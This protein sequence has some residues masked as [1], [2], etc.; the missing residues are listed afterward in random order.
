MRPQ[1]VKILTLM[2]LAFNSITL[3]AQPKGGGSSPPPPS[4]RLPPQYPIDDSIFILFFIGL[5][6]GAYVAFKRY[7]AKNTPA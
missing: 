1:I 6:F 4:Q 5:L 2:L 7:Q 3:L